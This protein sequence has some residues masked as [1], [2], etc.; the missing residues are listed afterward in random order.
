[1]GRK[2]AYIRVWKGGPTE[3]EQRNALR[4]AGVEMEGMGAPVYV[5]A[6][7]PRQMQRGAIVLKDRETCIRDMRSRPD[8][9]EPDELVVCAP[10]IL[11]ISP[12]DL[13]G[14]ASKLA[15]KG[16]VIHDLTSGQ[17]LRWTPE[18]AGLAAM[19][20]TIARFQNKRKTDQAR[21]TLATGDIK[22]GPKPKLSG[23]LLDL[24]M[25]DWGD[26]YAGTNEEVA[27]RHG[28]SVTTAHRIAGMSRTE[29]IRRAQRA[30]HDRME[31]ET[32]IKAGRRR[33]PAK[34]QPST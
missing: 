31:P 2:R 28:I 23:R 32:P 7:S 9:E 34:Q 5:D 12:S 16:A 13:F 19:A 15:E 8:G 21:L 20:E 1:M 10:W 3:E 22:T 27:A 4:S 11:A 30:K 14:V 17:R 26:A 6:P 33:K 24:F 18:I 29:A 25:T